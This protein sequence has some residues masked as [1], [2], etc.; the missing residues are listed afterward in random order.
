[1]K[2]LASV[3]LGLAA[4]PVV[5]CT[6]P[7]MTVVPVNVHDPAAKAAPSDGSS[8]SD[9][10]ETS[11]APSH[12]TPASTTPTK[13]VQADGSTL[14]AL[15]GYTL[16][17]DKSDDVPASTIDALATEFLRVYPVEA[18]RFN[19]FAARSVKLGFDA[20]M[21][22]AAAVTD[23]ANAT[24][25]VSTPYILAN[26]KDVDVMAHEGFH[27]VEDF[28]RG[29]DTGCP[30]WAIEGLADYAR[31]RYGLKNADSDWT[32]KPLASTDKPTDGYGTTAGFLVWLE[33][34]VRPMIVLDLF[35]ALRNDQYSDAFWTV[36]T[37]KSLDEL[38]AEYTANPALTPVNGNGCTVGKTFCGGDTVFGATDV[39][40]RCADDATAA[41]VEKCTTGCSAG[42]CKATP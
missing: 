7:E 8:T 4:L 16:I 27:V 33:N 13:S 35:D 36:R 12:P 40:F 6:S 41:E 28:P 9:D 30:V 17:A 26:P 18:L 10:A 29:G 42:A 25:T 1:M 15:G 5:A 34:H 3:V 24:I 22:G 32:M 23:S 31:N 14:Y 21:Q 11:P 19:G 2:K 20:T 39:V 37:S 38:W